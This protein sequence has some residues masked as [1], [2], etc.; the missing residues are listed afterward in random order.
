MEFVYALNLSFFFLNADFEYFVS[1]YYF[2]LFAREEEEEDYEEKIEQ[3]LAQQDEDDVEKIK[4]ESRK[5]RLAILEKYNKQKQLAQHT[6]AGPNN[7][8]KGN[9]LLCLDSTL[10]YYFT[11]CCGCFCAIICFYYF[12]VLVLSM[13]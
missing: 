8:E 13:P 11:F 12:D 10:W 6:E 1:I 7:H 5:R 9:S 3:Q 2:A 4:E